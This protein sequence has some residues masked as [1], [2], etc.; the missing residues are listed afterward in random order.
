MGLTPAILDETKETSID[1][2]A[3]VEF[4]HYNYQANSIVISKKQEAEG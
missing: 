4:T 3:V 2:L 1:L